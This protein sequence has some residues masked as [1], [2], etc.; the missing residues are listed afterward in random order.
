MVAEKGAAAGVQMCSEPSRKGRSVML[1]ACFEE[2]SCQQCQEPVEARWEREGISGEDRK[3]EQVWEL[4]IF[5][6]DKSLCANR[7]QDKRRTP[8]FVDENDCG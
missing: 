8:H 3:W 1:P 5:R 4:Q 2:R 7:A 6:E